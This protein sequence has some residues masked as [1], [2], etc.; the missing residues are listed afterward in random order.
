MLHSFII[1]QK[2]L[3]ILNIS[4]SLKEAMLSHSRRATNL[5]DVI[6][7]WIPPCHFKLKLIFGQI[8]MWVGDDKFQSNNSEIKAAITHNSCHCRQVANHISLV[9]SSSD[10]G[11]GMNEMGN[12]LTAMAVTTYLL[13]SLPFSLYILIFNFYFPSLQIDA[14]G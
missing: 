3:V 14:R 2:N 4:P 11:C 8:V 10:G 5:S 13:L 6:L 7:V 12:E 9:D 1:L